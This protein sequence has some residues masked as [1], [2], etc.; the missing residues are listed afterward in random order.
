MIC[1]QSSWCYC[2]SII[3]C[4]IKIQ[5]DLT[6]SGAG[7]SSL[8]WKKGRKMHVCLTETDMK[9]I[10]TQL[11]KPSALP[12]KYYRSKNVVQECS[13]IW[14]WIIWMCSLFWKPA[15]PVNCY[16]WAMW[17]NSSSHLAKNEFVFQEKDCFLV[18]WWNV[19]IWLNHNWHNIHDTYTFK[20]SLQMHLTI[21]C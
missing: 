18:Q 10:W 1:M 6:F 11:V 14:H 15:W 16:A 20:T 3:S 4:F 17:E 8:C 2:H 21:K 12:K 9:L 19:S 5:T 13:T 7:L